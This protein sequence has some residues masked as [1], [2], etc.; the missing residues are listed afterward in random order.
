ME[1]DKTLEIGFSNLFLQC[2]Q[3]IS[4]LWKRSNFLV[5]RENRRDSKFIIFLLQC[6]AMQWNEMEW[7]E[8]EREMIPCDERQCYEGL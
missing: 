5:I 1:L 6:N 2:F 8:M 3:N 4:I 7:N